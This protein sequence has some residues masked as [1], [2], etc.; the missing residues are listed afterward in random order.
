MVEPLYQSKVLCTFCGTNFQTSRVRPSFKK[1]LKTDTD[2]CVHYKGNNP[3]YYIVRVCPFCG[4]SSTE[5]FSD[6]FPEEKK[7]VFLEKVANQWTLR[8]LGGERSWDDALQTFKLALLCAQIKGESDRVIASLL[9]HIAWMYRFADN[10]LQERRFTEHAL[11]S[12]IKVYETESGSI[13][14]AKL[15]Y[16]IGELHRR[17]SDFNEAVKW[18][19]RVINDQKIMDAAMIRA[20]RDQWAATREEMV[21][22]KMELPEEML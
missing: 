16:L 1:A 18:F 4:F 11:A 14:N 6:Q 19:G 20:C 2:F 21:A 15:M 5:S 17:L 10:Q 22:S 3:D 9:H 8:E 13:N 7:Q 12:Y